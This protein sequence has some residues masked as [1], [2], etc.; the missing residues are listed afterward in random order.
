MRPSAK[1]EYACLA[2]LSLAMRPADAPPARIRELADAHN[3]PERY[4][5]QILLRL[6]GAGLVESVRGASGGY[7]LSREADRIDL[8]QVL[9][10]IDGPLP[11][12]HDGAHGAAQALNDVWQRITDAQRRLLRETSLATL[13]AQ[14]RPQEWVI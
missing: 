5:V 6:K 11:T 4:L 2:L 13:V 12:P 9:E 7:R 1:A 14:T 3:I 8:A 10:A